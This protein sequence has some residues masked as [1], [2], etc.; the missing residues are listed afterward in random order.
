MNADIL[1]FG[2]DGKWKT[3]HQQ[4]KEGYLQEGVVSP[5]EVGIWVTCA[6]TQE[7]KAAREVVAMFEEVRPSGGMSGQVQ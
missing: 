3:T 5:G 2:N 7:N 1:Q 6:R 4:S